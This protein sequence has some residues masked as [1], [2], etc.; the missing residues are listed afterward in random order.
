MSFA[1]GPVYRRLLSRSGRQLDRFQRPVRVASFAAVDVPAL[2]RR[3]GPGSNGQQLL[4]QQIRS[5]QGAART[6]RPVTPSFNFTVVV[7]FDMGLRTLV[8][9]TKMSLPDVSLPP[10]LKQSTHVRLTEAAGHRSRPSEVRVVTMVAPDL[11]TGTTRFV[12]SWATEDGLQPP[13]GRM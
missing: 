5:L 9:K 2:L 11:R 1:I 10:M 4:A 13:K 12:T 6:H 8:K 3:R 7:A